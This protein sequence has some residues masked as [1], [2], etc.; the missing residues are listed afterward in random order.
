METKF[1]KKISCPASGKT[2]GAIK[3]MEEE[4]KKGRKFVVAAISVSLCDQILKDFSKETKASMLVTDT[5]AR[6]ELVSDRFMSS[7][8]D[9]S[10]DILIITHH[11]LFTCY[12][13]LNGTG[14][15]LVVDE[16]PN[17]HSC[18]FL[19]IPSLED[20]TFSRWLDYDDAELDTKTGYRP[21]KLRVGYEDKLKTYLKNFEEVTEDE[22]FINKGSYQGLKG[23]L[24]GDSKVLRKQ[25]DDDLGNILV[26]YAFNSVYDPLVLFK[27]FEEVV[28]LCA[29]FDQQLTGILFNHKFN[30]QVEDK[31]EINLRQTSYTKP[32][33][34][35]IYP[36]I[37]AP[38][39]FSKKL[40]SSWYEPST[41][42]KYGEWLEKKEGYV[43]FFEHMVSVAS[44]IVGDEGYIY[45]VNN[46]R[47]EM[48]EK[49]EYN[50]LHESDKV[51]RLKYN[52]HG[53]NH[54]MDYNISLGLFCC[55]PKPIQLMLFKELDKECNVR[56]GTF[57]KGYIATAMN[58][59]IFQL[60]TRT[61]IRRFD[62]LEDIVCI[63]P[64]YRSVDYLLGGWFEGAE[65]DWSYAI[66]IA[67]AKIGAP[68]SWR[69]VF[70]M[71]DA[72]YK[73]FGRWCLRE[74]KTKPKDLNI[75]NNG[76]YKT[77]EDWINERRLK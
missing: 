56:Q 54:Y 60:V 38:K 17:I 37:K 27:G 51:K 41:K 64:D 40:S 46:F 20:D 35:K 32:S 75:T 48:I 11:T 45:T 14:W 71:N 21:M 50:F 69:G 43:E 16:L 53:L 73:A 63:V 22:S 59:P 61:K 65:V 6:N 55:N 42:R 66:D 58:D 10:E 25:S 72:E 12:E 15:S 33:R 62:V 52:P 30:I 9:K 77:V 44:D 28:F 2:Y 76:D 5:V 31:Q 3:Y 74:L 34:I 49:G 39:V 7:L 57:E 18:K 68:K 36:L 24:N 13:K 19:K 4:I 70:N 1:Y 23:I 26:E 8:E 67:D 29:E 47:T